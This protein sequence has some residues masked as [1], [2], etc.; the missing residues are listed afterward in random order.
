MRL[1]DSVS[2]GTIRDT[3]T[4][5]KKIWH[6]GCDEYNFQ[7][8]DPFRDL[9]EFIPEDPV[10]EAE[11]G[12][13]PPPPVWRFDAAMLILECMNK[14]QVNVTRLMFL[15]G[16]SASEIAGIRQQDIQGD[17]LLIRNFVTRRSKK[18]KKTGKTKYRRRVIP[19]TRA[20]RACLDEA[21]SKSTDEYLFR[22]VTGLHFNCSIYGDT[23]WKPAVRR[24]GLP[25]MKPYSTRHTF[26]AWALT[27]GKS[28]HQLVNLMGHGSKKMVYEVYGH[29][30]K[31]LDEDLE[32]IREFMGEDF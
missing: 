10:V 4:V 9:E 12:L 16:L 24:A 31:G 1:K 18:P 13:K 14:G 28:P 26:V 27:L 19:I 2:S 29:W 30:T 8:R 22:T 21:R 5:L 17:E 15:T 23:Y 11:N 32:K 6:S 3:L 20:I 7:L 25:Y